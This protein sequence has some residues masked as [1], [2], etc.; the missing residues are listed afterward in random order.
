MNAVIGSLISKY[1]AKRY[2]FNFCNSMDTLHNY[3]SVVGFRCVS[4]HDLSIENT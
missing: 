1:F 4:I 2:F 3:I